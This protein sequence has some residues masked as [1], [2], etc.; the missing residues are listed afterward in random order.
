MVRG[1]V[2]LLGQ[3]ELPGEGKELLGVLDMLL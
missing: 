3:V 2:L 1:A